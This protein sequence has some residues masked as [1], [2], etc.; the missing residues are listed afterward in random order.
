MTENNEH[1]FEPMRS[2]EKSL[3][4]VQIN[5]AMMASLFFILTLI[6][7]L[8]PEKFNIFIIGQLVLA[9]PLLFISS[10]SYAKIGY[11]DK[12]HWF[13]R[14]GWITTTLG[15]N[16]ILNVAGLMAGKFYRELAYAY[17]ALVIILVT[18]YYLINILHGKESLKEELA[19]LAIVILIVILGGI[20]PL[21]LM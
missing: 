16:F 5:G 10:L 3:A 20:L 12:W 2:P 14:F 9:I 19:K 4:R 7:T 6:W 15:N 1:H 21:I 18:I 13:N 11:R 17:F 8:G